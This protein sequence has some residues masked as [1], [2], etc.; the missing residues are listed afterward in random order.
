LL[1]DDIVSGL[2]EIKF[3][4]GRFSQMNGFTLDHAWDGYSINHILKWLR[5][6]RFPVSVYAVDTWGK[7]SVKEIVKSKTSIVSICFMIKDGHLY[8][9]T[10]GKK[11]AQ[12]LG[13]K[14]MIQL[15]STTKWSAPKDNTF[16]VQERGD[17]IPDK[18][19]L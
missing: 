12:S 13:K 18:C 1:L 11:F 5:K 3:E 9:M 15:M 4:E 19:I 6:M 17:T 16:V 7:I 14:S 2:D 8:P 10:G